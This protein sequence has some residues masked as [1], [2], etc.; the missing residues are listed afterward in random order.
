MRNCNK[1]RRLINAII[2]VAVA[3][4][5][6][7]VGC[8]KV[9]DTLGFELT[10]DNQEMKIGIKKFDPTS[11]KS[12]FETRL[13]RT[14]SIMTSGQ[15]YG[16][17]GSMRNDTFGLRTVGLLSQFIPMTRV[18]TN[19]FGFRPIFDS[20]QLVFAIGS[21]G[22]DTTINQEFEIYEVED[23]SFIKSSKDSVFFASF[24]PT[25]YVARQPLFTFTFPDKNKGVYTSSTALT[26]TPTT[27]GRQF[28]KRLML[29]EGKYKD[30]NSVYESD[31][32]WVDYFKGLYIKPKND[33]AAQRGGIYST[34]L[35]STGLVIYGRNRNE[36]DPTLIKDTVSAGYYLYYS[37]ATAG[38]VSLNTVKHD[39]LGSQINDA[40]VKKSR[41]DVTEYPTNGICFVEGMSGVVTEITFTE[42]FF[43]GLQAIL[44]EENNKSAQDGSH[45]VFTT[46]AFNQA[47]L[48]VYFRQ[49]DYDIQKIVIGELFPWMDDAPKRLGLYTDYSN[50]Y[51]THTA[52][53]GKYSSIVPI[54]D[55]NYSYE[56][57]YNTTLPYGGYINRSLGRYEFNISSYLQSLWNRYLKV[58][59]ATTLGERVDMTKVENRTIYLAP[60]AGSLQGFSYVTL[61][62]MQNG[63]NN[64]PIK[65]D[66]TYTMIK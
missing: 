38:N 59:A 51:K 48:D 26:L 39:Y 45:R 41:L 58:K 65:L 22:G 47:V 27:A 19:G 2:V 35:A 4:I 24:D 8:T 31:T 16:Y 63:T 30:D 57:S 5:M 13:F 42:T 3:A 10:P 6:T 49:S 15:K 1:T 44:D 66:L 54:A 20:A 11:G 21:Y 12:F 32:T 18:D 29:L 33:I 61:Q 23:N 55:Y 14:D 56:N 9:D 52:S 62:G 34:E 43:E 53:G 7:F 40:E 25:A 64:A 60:E 17:F 37:G 28:V 46:L 50:Y 36:T